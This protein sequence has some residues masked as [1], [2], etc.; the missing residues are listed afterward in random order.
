M[1]GPIGDRN[2]TDAPARHNAI[3]AYGSFQLYRGSGRSVAISLVF[4]E[5]AILCSV[6]V[7]SLSPIELAFYYAV[8]T[9]AN[10]HRL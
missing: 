2:R 10:S 9:N 3:D 4:E 6:H 7:W 5:M 1:C 8:S